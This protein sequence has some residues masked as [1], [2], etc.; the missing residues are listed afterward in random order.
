MSCINNEALYETI[1]EEFMEELT[2]TDTLDK[3]SEREILKICN[4]RFEDMCQWNLL[5]ANLST[6]LQQ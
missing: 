2:L 6:R 3:Y 1:Y 4:Q 5:D